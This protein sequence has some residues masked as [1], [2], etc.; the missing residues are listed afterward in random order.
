[1]KATQILKAMALVPVAGLMMG[2]QSCQQQQAVQK[3]TYKK[4]VEMG[5]IAAQPILLPDG[6]SFDFKFVANQQMYGVIADNG[7]F[8]LRG[9]SLVVSDP[10]LSSTSSLKDSQAF[11]LSANDKTLLQKSFDVSQSD[12]RAA[13]SRTA[14]CMVN[15]PQAKLYGSI[16]SFE[17]IGGGGLSLGYTPTGPIGGIAGASVNFNVQSA[18]LDLSMRGLPALGNTILGATNV[19]SKQTKT[20]IGLNINFGLFSVGPSFYYSTPLATVVKKGLTTGL[21]QLATQMSNDEWYT[22]VFADQDTSVI[23]V[24]G[25][26]VGF[27]VGDQLDIYNEQ[28]AWDGEPCNSNYLGGVGTGEDSY[29]ARV[30]ITSVGDQLSQAKVIK[31]DPNAVQGFASV[32]AK[33]KLYMLKED[34]AAPSGT[35]KK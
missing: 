31:I 16:N 23:L 27:E 12:F 21:D 22:R 7:N 33:V 4:I 24:G 29:Y 11:N 5:S 9:N 13:F 32:G 8:S 17:I 20:N 15:L 2:N 26:D 18:Q 30:E 25:T 28:Y 35:T 10:S 19:T 1:M 14:W 3:R 6:S 34:L